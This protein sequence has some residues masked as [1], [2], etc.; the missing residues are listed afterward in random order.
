[1]VLAKSCTRPSYKRAVNDTEL[2]S[3]LRALEESCKHSLRVIDIVFFF[4]GS[5]LLLW[6][7][8][9]SLRRIRNLTPVSNVCKALFCVSGHEYVL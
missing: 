7:K 9:A 1:M 6:L 2:I 4:Q 3:Y 5:V 8:N